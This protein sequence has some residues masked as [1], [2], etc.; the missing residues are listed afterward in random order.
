MSS[1]TFRKP[2]FGIGRSKAD[3]LLKT[4]RW[5]RR[6]FVVC[7]RTC[8]WSRSPSCVG[9]PCAGVVRKLGR[10]C[11]DRLS[12]PR[13]AL[14]RCRTS[15][16]RGSACT[17]TSRS[18]TLTSWQGVSLKA[19]SASTTQ[20]SPPHLLSCR[21]TP[22]KVRPRALGAR[23]LCC[24]R[25]AGRCALLVCS[26]RVVQTRGEPT[27]WSQSSQWCARPDVDKSVLAAAG[28]SSAAAILFATVNASVFRDVVV[29]ARL[30]SL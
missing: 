8:S 12:E 20:T 10:L 14:R 28:F 17:G 15:S 18:S 11:A 4:A 19:P 25:R 22:C 16:S 2:C 29:M 6:S 24:R 27:A 21:R 30:L 5:Q 1:A 7:A 26:P 3:R 23:S 13:A 9:T